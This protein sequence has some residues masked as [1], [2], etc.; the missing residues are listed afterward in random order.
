MIF[1]V[2]SP[3]AVISA[4]E[5]PKPALALRASRPLR[6]VGGRA[7]N[8]ATTLLTRR[9]RGTTERWWRGYAG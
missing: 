8:Q 3:A 9:G 2:A 5:R 4:L 1:L 6:H 7:I